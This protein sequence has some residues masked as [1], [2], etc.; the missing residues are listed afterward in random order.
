MNRQQLAHVLRAACEITGDARVLVVGSQA[1]LGSF[2]EDNLPSSATAS[3]EADIAFFDDQSRGK[4]DAVEGAIGEFSAFHQMNGYYAEGIHIDTV[5]L[6]KGWEDRVAGWTLVSSQPAEPLFLDVH[7]LG[8]A[9]LMAG[10]EKDLEF[11]GAL[12]DCGMLN[13]GVLVE[14][15]ELLPEDAH[16][17]AV[18]RVRSY[19]RSRADSSVEES[20]DVKPS[21]G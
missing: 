5:V 20:P 16:S 2:D 1:I 12:I 4:A 8:I 18:G 21:S 13:L 3:L 11:V 7:D 6:P 10:R 14:R 17:E 9:K 19:L 15:C